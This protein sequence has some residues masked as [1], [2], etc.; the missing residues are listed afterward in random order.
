MQY[1]NRSIRHACIVVLVW[2]LLFFRPL[3]TGIYPGITGA[4]NFCEFCTASI[5]VPGTSVGSVR[6]SYPYPKLLQVLYARATI[7]GVRVQHS[8]TYPELP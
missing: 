3:E 6:H 5:P 7:P 4:G 2:F 1:T 8:Y